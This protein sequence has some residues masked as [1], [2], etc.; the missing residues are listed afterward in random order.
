MAS[1]LKTHGARLHRLDLCVAPTQEHVAALLG[2]L[3]A[4]HLECLTVTFSHIC[5]SSEDTNLS[6]TP[7]LNE[8]ASSLRALAL[9]PVVDWMPSCTFPH[10]TH[11]FISFDTDT[12]L[13]HSLDLLELL[14][15]TPLLAFLHVSFLLFDA[16]N[17]QPPS[18]TVPLYQLRSLVSTS[19]SY[20]AMRT[21]LS[22]L[23]LPEDVF[24][25]LHDIYNDTDFDR[26]PAPLPSLPLRPV[27]SLGLSMRCEQILIVADGSTFGLWFNGHLDIGHG[28]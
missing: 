6:W 26:S 11:L 24:I 12:D 10:L 27:T 20:D 22:H 16:D 17:W 1:V 8:D 13:Y 2:P 28:F 3:Q 19:C 18:N 23:A 21:V 7:L 25:R 4:P 15:N 14:V 9:M 5:A